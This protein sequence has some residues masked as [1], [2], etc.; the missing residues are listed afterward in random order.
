MYKVVQSRSYQLL[1][2][3]RSISWRQLTSACSETGVERMGTTGLVHHTPEHLQQCLAVRHD[4]VLG[5]ERVAKDGHRVALDAEVAAQLHIEANLHAQQPILAES[6]D[7]A[8]QR[9]QIQTAVT[10]HC[11]MLTVHV[12]TGRQLPEKAA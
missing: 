3:R 8:A 1:L 6:K 4:L 5:H 10:Q 2:P 11:H 12:M 9:T 7:A